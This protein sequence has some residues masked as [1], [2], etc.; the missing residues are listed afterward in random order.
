[1]TVPV[2]RRTFW[3]FVLCATIAFI[4]ET[5]VGQETCLD[6]YEFF[7][8]DDTM[9]EASLITVSI[10]GDVLVQEHTLHRGDDTDW[11]KFGAI[12][13][14][15][16][17]L[18]TPQVGSDIFM[19]AEVYNG[20]GLLLDCYDDEEIPEAHIGY[21]SFPW[22]TGV[23]YFRLV[24]RFCV[25]SYPPSMCSAP[26]EME[27]GCPLSGADSEYTLA[28]RNDSGTPST[29]LPS[30][31]SLATGEPI[32]GAN[33]WAKLTGGETFY[34]DD[35]DEDGESVI[36]LM[37]SGDCMVSADHDDYV[38]KT[39]SFDCRGTKPMTLELEPGND[40]GTTQPQC[41]ASPPGAPGDYTSLFFYGAFF[42]VIIAL[43][44]TRMTIRDQSR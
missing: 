43:A 32:G 16:I 38:R 40:P 39:T 20:E 24:N 23:Y 41:G 8:G 12:Q 7:G 13:G 27:P 28:A 9:D 2:A 36:D 3:L 17:E 44:R 18:Y 33:V 14:D 25:A 5:V 34:G 35:T 19:Y 15:T 30:V 26:V 29:V 11:V 21:M 10:Q 1:M 4:P 37:A 31:L 6:G 42:L 22:E